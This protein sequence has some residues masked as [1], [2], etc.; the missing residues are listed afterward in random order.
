MSIVGGGGVMLLIC[1]TPM[2]CLPHYLKFLTS[3]VVFM[4]G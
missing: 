3:F 1:P 4:G 2:I